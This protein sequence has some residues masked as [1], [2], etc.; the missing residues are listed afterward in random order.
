A[1]WWP[2]A[3]WPMP[4]R[5][6]TGCV[7]FSTLSPP[8]G[9]LVVRLESRRGVGDGV[10]ARCSHGRRGTKRWDRAAYV[11]M[12]GS[13][14]WL[15]YQA[16]RYASASIAPYQTPWPGIAIVP[17]TGAHSCM[18]ATCSVVARRQ[19]AGSCSVAFAFDRL[20]T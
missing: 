17:P 10:Q 15:R 18:P 12:G 4:V 1:H 3:R 5:C 11:F 20:K 19:C 7:V 16:S 14:D 6:S 2:R 9:M 13:A 8:E